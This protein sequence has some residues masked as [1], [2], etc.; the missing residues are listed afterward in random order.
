MGTAVEQVSAALPAPMLVVFS[1]LLAVGVVVWLMGRSLA[2]PACVLSGLALGAAG[3]LAATHLGSFRG[4][5]MLGI[6]VGGG[7]AGAVLA[8][9]LFRLW[10]AIVGAV[11]LALIVPAGL[12]VWH[13]TDPP[14]FAATQATEAAD[15]GGNGDEADDA[16]EDGD[17]AIPG[18]SE[19][20]A[21]T[22]GK[23]DSGAIE[24]A[25]ES[26]EGL[27]AKQS[28]AI[29][30]WWAGLE[31]TTRRRLMY[32]CGIGAAVGLVLGLLAPLTG[33][34]IESAV[35]G[36]MLIFFPGRALLSHFFPEQAGWLP[37]SPR[38]TV[39]WLCLITLAGFW[40]Q[41]IT[42]RKSADK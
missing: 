36:A 17:G 2:R 18:V 30:D 38:W 33:A 29:G 9:M 19:V 20:A 1:M 8:A 15:A 37:Q 16:G 23:S 35:A 32:G 34:A 5:V 3:G 24:L 11:L 7:I 28:E 31:T 26:L 10:V 4:L 21:A 6:V 14:S 12:I 22:T 25:A 27:H 42:T 13:G 41:W 39:L 40:L